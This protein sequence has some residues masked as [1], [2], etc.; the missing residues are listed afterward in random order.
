MNIG[1]LA[2]QGARKRTEVRENFSN[3]ELFSYK[4]EI[5]RIGNQLQGAP[6]GAPPFALNRHT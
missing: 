6:S 3:P 5:P 4:L 1:I 2:K